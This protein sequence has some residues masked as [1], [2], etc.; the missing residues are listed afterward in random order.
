M[1]RDTFLFQESEEVNTWKVRRFYFRKPKTEMGKMRRFY[2]R[3]L[4]RVICG[5]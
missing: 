3:K 4:K 2:F 1:E 5:K